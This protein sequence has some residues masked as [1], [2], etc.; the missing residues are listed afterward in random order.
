MT[1][2]YKWAIVGTQSWHWQHIALG[3]PD[4]SLIKK[5]CEE[6]GAA[7]TQNITKTRNLEIGRG[8]SGTRRLDVVG[9][10]RRNRTIPGNRM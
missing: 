9:I 7:C 10:Q 3:S 8:S 5:R 2:G 1:L 6:P 4:S